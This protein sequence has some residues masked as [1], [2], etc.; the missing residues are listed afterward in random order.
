[1]EKPKETR[2]VTIRAKIRRKGITEE[3]VFDT[4]IDYF[5]KFGKD[6]KL[7]VSGR[8]KDLEEKHIN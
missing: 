5:R 8:D 6:F 7:E 3:E 2:S 1:M 4:L